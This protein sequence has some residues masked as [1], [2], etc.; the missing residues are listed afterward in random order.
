M[1]LG[2]LMED[3]EVEDREE[4]EESVGEEEGDGE[5]GGE[6]SEEEVDGEGGEEIQVGEGGDDED[7]E[8]ETLPPS[9]IDDCDWTVLCY[10]IHDKIN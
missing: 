2:D 3:E 9:D 8:R 4:D 1:H 6:G 10:S 5:E 7:Y